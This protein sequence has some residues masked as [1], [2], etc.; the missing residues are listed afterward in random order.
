MNG[1]GFLPGDVTIFWDE[2][3]E[4]LARTEAAD[5]GSF[6]IIVEVPEDID[7]GSYRIVAQDSDGNT[8]REKFLVVD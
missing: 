3:D 5:D 1:D 7:G 4:P 8:A 2:D 6:E